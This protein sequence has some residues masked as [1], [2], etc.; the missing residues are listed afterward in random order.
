MQNYTQ[1]IYEKKPI[2]IVDCRM[3]HK[4]IYEKAVLKKCW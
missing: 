2:L 1:N 3:L 4:R